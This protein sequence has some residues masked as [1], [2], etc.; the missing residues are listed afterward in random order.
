[1][2]MSTFMSW[3]LHGGRTEDGSGAGTRVS[4]PLPKEETGHE[5]RIES[6]TAEGGPGTGLTQ[7]SAGPLFVDFEALAHRQNALLEGLSPLREQA[8]L[9]SFV[10]SGITEPN[11]YEDAVA[12]NNQ[13][14]LKAPTHDGAL[15]QVFTHKPHEESE[16]S[17]FLYLHFVGDP[18]C[19]GFLI[20]AL[21]G[22]AL[23]AGWKLS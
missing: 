11:R 2:A 16:G 5:R 18:L 14:R 17:D 13:F 4:C 7:R 22:G 20:C 19:F 23:M 10:G 21:T 3:I 9:V 8:A 12:A 15:T 6:S 1:M